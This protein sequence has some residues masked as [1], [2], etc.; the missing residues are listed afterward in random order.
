MTGGSSSQ[1]VRDSQL[2]GCNLANTPSAFLAAIIGVSS[3]TAA[4]PLA[5]DLPNLL[6]LCEDRLRVIDDRRGANAH[7]SNGQ[8]SADPGHK[9]THD[10]LQGFMKVC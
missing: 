3:A 9:S 4:I 6:G 8:R 1:P 7:C 10:V 2:T 5:G